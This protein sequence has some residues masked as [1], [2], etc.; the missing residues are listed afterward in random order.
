[1]LMKLE[2]AIKQRFSARVYDGSVV[3]REKLD[4]CLELARHSPSARNLQPYKF[5]VC[6][7]RGIVSNIALATQTAGMKINRYTRGVPCFV[8]LVGERVGLFK[9]LTTSA[10]IHYDDF[11]IGIAAQ[12]FCLA[13][14]SIGLNVC[15]IG[16]FDRKKIAKLLQLPRDREVRLLIAVGAGGAEYKERKKKPFTELVSYNK[17]GNLDKGEE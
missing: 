5:V 17:Y 6:D 16:W 11:D 1:M 13:A 14:T 9:K 7:N 3:D 8:A 12:T 10:H 4:Y 2:D 15:I